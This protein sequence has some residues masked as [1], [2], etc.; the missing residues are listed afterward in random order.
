MNFKKYK[1]NKLKHILKE[2]KLIYICSY[3]DTKLKNWKTI[4]QILIK[5]KL[6][7]YK[8]SNTILIKLLNNSI[9]K[10][11]IPLINGPIILLYSHEVPK[12]F[13]YSKLKNLLTPNI[14]ILC[15][16][17]NNRIYSNN[18]LNNISIMYNYN[19]ILLTKVLDNI[20]KKGIFKI[21]KIS[22]KS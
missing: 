3:K 17:I 11:I 15:T 9:F 22:I 1:I 14:K 12:N 21:K 13:T 8:I 19:I 6:R 10:G 16:K 5:S 4:E 7:Y 18:Q 20:N 2:K